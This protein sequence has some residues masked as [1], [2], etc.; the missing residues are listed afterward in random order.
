MFIGIKH[1]SL[2]QR[3]VKV[4]TRFCRATRTTKAVFKKSYLPFPPWRQPQPLKWSQPIAE[5]KQRTSLSFFRRH[6]IWPN[7]TR[8]NDAQH[9]DMMCDCY[10]WIALALTVA[11]KR[12][13]K[14]VVRLIVV[15][16][17]V[18]APTFQELHLF[19]IELAETGADGAPARSPAWR[20]MALK[21]FCP[22]ASPPAA[23]FRP[24]RT[25]TGTVSLSRLSQEQQVDRWVGWQNKGNN[26]QQIWLRHVTTGLGCKPSTG[27]AFVK[28]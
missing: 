24:G 4:F 25:T 6:H 19:S 17:I 10:Y 22:P 23:R 2:L 26:N 9:D 18:A 20:H 7:G 3:S 16:A 13:G 27:V 12:T 21:W 15:T 5:T 1:A 8:P 11:V 14:S 28:L